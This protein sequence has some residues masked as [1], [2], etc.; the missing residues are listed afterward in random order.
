MVYYNR[1]NIKS[2]GS[3]RGTRT[4]LSRKNSFTKQIILL[5]IPMIV[6]RNFYVFYGT[7]DYTNRH[8]GHKVLMTDFVDKPNIGDILTENNDGSSLEVS[9]SSSRI[10]K[11]K[12]GKRVAIVVSGSLRRYFFQ[13][14]LQHL[15]NPL[16]EQ[17]HLVDYYLALA[18]GDAP[19]YRSDAGYM[20]YMDYDPILK[21]GMEHN[22][23]KTTQLQDYI[24]KKIE[25]VGG[26]LKHAILRKRFE[27]EHNNLLKQ[28]REMSKTVLF[29]N[30]EDPDIAFPLKDFRSAQVKQRTSNANR[31]L[32]S[33]HLGIEEL[34]TNAQNYENE[35]EWKYDYVMYLRDDTQWLSDFDLNKLL[36]LGDADIYILSCDARQP[37]LHI[38]E[39]NDHA[40]VVKRE[41]ADFF[42]MYFTNLFKEKDLV[43]NCVSNMK[44]SKIFAKRFK[45]TDT[46][47]TSVRGCN[48]EMLLKYLIEENNFSVLKVGQSYL[49]FQRSVHLDMGDDKG[50]KMTCF[51]KYCQS[52][53]NNLDDRGIKRCKDIAI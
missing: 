17:G 45:N 1:H 47:T 43:E 8:D 22:L 30:E 32:L 4:M 35:N 23:G 15:I 19:A 6:L 28:R 40:L 52:H 46:T 27:I 42:G 18:M 5:A 11:K 3:K 31:N 41:V 38:D 2:I 53:H 34:W 44:D 20:N 13:S 49:P 9:P 29:P 10:K 48:S 26:K 24:G 50:G 25:L 16:S 33:M 12:N 37:P 39:I 7:S 14:S 36:S 51:H 21:D